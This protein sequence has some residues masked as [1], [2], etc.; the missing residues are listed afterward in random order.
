MTDQLPTDPLAV[1]PVQE[2]GHEE[3]GCPRIGIVVFSKD[4]PLQ[5]DATLQSLELNVKDL[6]LATV[7]VLYTTSSPYYESQYRILRGEHPGV[8]WLRE[9][10]FKADLLE[11]SGSVPYLL[12]V[13]DDTLFV[14]EVALSATASVL[15]TDRSTVGFSF[16]LGRNTTYCYTLDK[17][18][19]LPVFEA[20]GPGLLQFDWTHSEHDFGYPLELSSSLY[21]SEDLL[22]LLSSLSYKNPN[23][24]EAALAA[25]VGVFAGSR[26]MLACCEQ[27]VA[28]S[29]PA[30]LV[31]TA[32]GN[33]MDGR[34]EVTAA[35]LGAQ[36]GEG[37]RLDVAHYKGHVARAA[38]EKL[39]FVFV[40]RLDIPAVSVIVPCY[41]QAEFL[42]DAIESVLAQTYDDWELLVIDDGSIDET[43]LV[44]ASMAESS[45][46]RRMRVIR[47]AN[48][49]LARARN[50][51]VNAARGRYVLPLDADDMLAPEM[52]HECVTYL[53]QHKEIA[54][55]YTDLQQF[56][57]ARER[58]NPRDFDAA[59]L[60]THNHLSYCALYRREVWEAVGGYNPN[61]LYGYEDWDFWIGCIEH[62]F[63][64]HHIREPLFLY[65][66][67]G[68]SMYRN[69]LAHDSELR[70]QI[71]KN[72][73]LLFTARK[74]LVR[75][76][77]FAIGEWRARIRWHVEH[78][79]L[80]ARFR[81]SGPP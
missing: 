55:V 67:R 35:S 75:K 37:R 39:P 70:R 26:P 24:L 17:P 51:G 42:P 57:E 64:A 76:M 32:W 6:D 23:T 43:A 11:L 5:L 61:M 81:S 41:N 16:R 44:A 49:G 29:V 47:Q 65:R 28:V 1:V 79:A 8:T 71:R 56:G 15:E 31:Q 2:T 18:Q 7:R 10:D 34:P 54:I 74:R 63:D 59:I 52:L 21:R 25:R 19:T 50:A 45:P 80:A 27:S 30:N 68:D 36:F 20:A 38:H 62:G 78:S 40:Q 66:V 33:R 58:V 46:G 73:P 69:A 48:S 3:S 77:R 60:P 13:V 22:P 4:R 9:R 72:H 12:F 53:N 14:G